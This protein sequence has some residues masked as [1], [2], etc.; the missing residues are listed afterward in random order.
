MTVS[1]GA[2]LAAAEQRVSVDDLVSMLGKQKQ[3]PSCGRQARWLTTAWPVVLRDLDPASSC[4]LLCWLVMGVL[5]TN[6]G[7]TS[8]SST[9]TPLLMW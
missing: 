5:C 7:S 1:V 9:C 8:A 2:G 3:Q 4:A 6:A